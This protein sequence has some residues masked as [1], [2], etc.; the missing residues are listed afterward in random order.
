MGRRLHPRHSSGERRAHRPLRVPS[1]VLRRPRALRLRP[2]RRVR[3]KARRGRSA[4][5]VCQVADVRPRPCGAQH[6]WRSGNDPRLL[7]KV[8][9][10][11]LAHVQR[12]RAAGVSSRG[13]AL[14]LA[15]PRRRR[16]RVYDRRRPRQ[17]PCT[18]NLRHVHRAAHG[19]THRRGMRRAPATHVFPR[20]AARQTRALRRCVERRRRTSSRDRGR[21]QRARGRGAARGRGRAGARDRGP[22]PA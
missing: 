12:P 9:E 6:G 21:L 4:S 10:V 14:P 7:C 5:C 3:R 8:R 2:R 20:K 18:Q 17:R 1:R 16:A 11:A 13:R 15:R 22:T 19:R